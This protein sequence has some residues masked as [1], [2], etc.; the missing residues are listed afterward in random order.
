MYGVLSLAAPSHIYPPLRRTIEMLEAP[1]N[2]HVLKS[3]QQF[4]DVAQF[5]FEILHFGYCAQAINGVKRKPSKIFQCTQV[6]TRYG[7]GGCMR[8]V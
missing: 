1:A 3:L 8:I 5:S 6:P 7:Q 2:L 4:A